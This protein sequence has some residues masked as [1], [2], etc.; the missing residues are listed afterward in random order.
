MGVGCQHHALAPLPTGK[1]AATHCTAGWVRPRP[2]WI[3]S[4]DN[5]A[6]SKSQY[7]L[8]YPSPELINI[9]E[10]LNK[11]YK[12]DQF[13]NIVKSHESNQPSM[14]STSKTRVQKN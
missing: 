1:R 8:R 2:V 3:Q 14:N 12:E 5:P 13:I 10:Y 6:H 9:A 7:Q 4:P 11:E